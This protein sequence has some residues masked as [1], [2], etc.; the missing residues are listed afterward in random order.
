MKLVY[1]E[2]ESIFDFDIDRVNSLVIENP[3]FLK[4]LL[5]DLKSQMDGLDGKAVLSENDKPVK[6]SKCIDFTEVFVPFE[7]NRKSLINKLIS[8][9]SAN[10]NEPE[11][12]LESSELLTSISEYLSRLSF[13]MP[14]RVDFNGISLNSIVKAASPCIVDDSGTLSESVINYM[15]TVTELDGIKLFCFYNFRAVVDNKELEKFSETVLKHGYKVFLIESFSKN[16]FS[17]ENRI[18]IDYDLCEI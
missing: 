17:L 4:E 7:V 14:C 3:S 2:I 11:F 18:T 13:G 10:G 5:F 6:I 16:R 1:P 9:I 8:K 12:F 15:E